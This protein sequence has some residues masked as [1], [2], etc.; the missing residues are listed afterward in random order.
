MN[1]FTKPFGRA[2]KIS[3]VIAI[4]V[5]MLCT[6]M[7]SACG[8][9]HELEKV[10]GKASTC[11]VEG[12]KE[13]YK[14]TVCGELFTDAEAKNPTD[15]EE[16]KLA[17]A[18]HDYSLRVAVAEGEYTAGEYLTPD[19]LS[20]SL[21]C[22]VCADEQSIKSGVTVDLSQPLAEGANSFTASYDGKNAAFSVTAKAEAVTLYE[23]KAEC[24]KIFHVGQTV[25]PADLTVTFNEVGGEPEQITDFTVINAEITADTEEISVTYGGLTASVPVT[26]HSVTF[27]E[28][29]DSTVEAEGV[30]EHY[31]CA[32]C[33][34]NYDIRFN[35][36]Q[37]VSIPLMQ[38]FSVT[39]PNV[40]ITNSDGKTVALKTENGKTFLAGNPNEYYGRIFMEYNLSVERDTAVKI[41]VNTCT[42]DGVVKVGDLYTVKINGVEVTSGDDTLPQGTINWF[43]EDYSLAGEGLLVAGRNNVVEIT[44]VN[45]IN[46][47]LGGGLT[48][49]Y[50]GIGI[51]PELSGDITLNAPC[52]HQ[53][54]YCGKC[55]DAESDSPA[56]AEKCAGHEGEHF[57]GHVCA[58]CGNCQ[59]PACAD[60]VCAEKCG[61]TEFSVMND[62]VVAVDKDGLTVNKNTAANEQNISAND[63]NAKK[64][65]IKITYRINSDKA[66]TVR[67]YIKT[68]SQTLENTLAE[69]YAFNVNGEP[70]AVDA[71]IKMPQNEA[72]KWNDVRYTCVGEI[73]L[74]EGVNVIE[75]IRLDM[76]DRELND[77]TGYNFFGIAL[78]GNASLTWAE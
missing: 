42:R 38:A 65:L 43:S 68:C 32:E 4:S 74:T 29:V 44:R 1:I 46:K 54:P 64:G 69:S 2:A 56:C 55:T 15:S 28:Q 62:N 34:K 39:D 67:L 27:T 73:T 31:Y 75:I 45:L 16:V 30:K 58:I 22:N 66:T 40:R 51:T 47:T 14:C 23:L 18:P 13:Y 8:H 41:Y 25:D 5:V 53:C 3:V 21:Y 78:S 50:F 26:V 48:Y 24:G 71:N 52:T 70:V 49:N 19:K 17:L 59:D 20:F 12:W 35:E 60:E 36:L 37:D 77:Y 63:S 7:F 76:T 61:C 57:C 72:N 10:E 11:T 6:V 9:K 33:G